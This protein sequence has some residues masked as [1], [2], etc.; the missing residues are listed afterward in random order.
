MPSDDGASVAL[1]LHLISTS[2]YGLTPRQGDGSDRWT[3]VGIGLRGPH[4]T[5][6]LATRPPV[7]WVEVHAE[8]YMRGGSAL[9]ALASVRR[10]YEVS[11]HGVGLSL[12]TANDLQRDHLARLASLSAQIRPTLVSEH[13]SWCA[14]S[15]TYFNALLPLP[16]TDETLGV[17]CRN[18]DAIQ[19]AL[20]RRILVENI[21]AYLRFQHSVIPEPEFL[22]EVA[23]RTGCGILCDI[24]NIFIT[25]TNFGLAPLD[26]LRA[27]SPAAVGQF[28]LGG[29]SSIPCQDR[30]LLFDDHGSTV[31]AAVSNLYR[32][33][34][35]RFGPRPT[36]IEWDTQ[37]PPLE[38]LLS[39]A[40]HAHDNISKWLSDS[41]PSDE[42]G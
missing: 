19:H 14:T 11:L 39:E 26:Y 40:R 5:E 18:V 10:D 12:G 28:H 37:L 31:D 4:V 22:T 20:G 36:V 41:V 23:R 42:T 9:R 21:A 38:V 13:L 25:C 29:H 30:R 34:M 7:G 33:A 16:Y 32:E 2:G 8:N 27:I 35:R 17:V 15:D 24:N 3:W 1:M 6:F